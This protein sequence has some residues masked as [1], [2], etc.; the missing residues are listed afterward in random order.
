[1]KASFDLKGQAVIDWTATEK[2]AR[3][4]TDAS[5][6]FAIRDCRKAGVASRHLENAGMRVSK[7]EGFYLDESYVFH[8]EL[9]RRRKA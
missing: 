8:K 2:Q 5:L 1:M 6:L 3:A 4:M 9:T 7:T